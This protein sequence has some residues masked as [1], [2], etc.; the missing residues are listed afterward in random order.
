VNIVVVGG[1]PVGSLLAW[2]LATGGSAVT[3]VRRRSTDEGSG[4]IVVARGGGSEAV[5]LDFA[6]STQVVDT[7][8]DAVVLAMKA[9]DVESTVAS[10]PSSVATV[11]T[12]QNGIGSEEAV[13]EARPQG[14]LIAAS[15]TAS[16]ELEPDGAVRWRRRGGIGLARVREGG[17]ISPDSLAEILERGGLPARVYADWRAMKWSK[18]IGN[19]VGNA[20]SALLDMTPG[21]VYQHPDLFEI[22]RSQLR[23]A[24]AVV[25][26]LGLD[27][28]GL[29]DADVRRLELALNAPAL[30][31]RPVLA[32][33]VASARGG[34][35]PSLRI[36]LSAAESAP[37]Q[38]EIAWL[39]GAVARTAG[40][41]GV[42]APVNAAL[43]ALVERSTTDASLR[44]SLRHQ[45]HAL[46]AAIGEFVRRPLS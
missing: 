11:V 34:K 2:V 12:V 23:E 24:F 30:L 10:L 44:A 32:R 31:S 16:V 8:T 13:L 19:L 41:V 35:E 26:A 6:R 29:P 5:P 3:L 40:S 46:V 14:S 37:V 15:L 33:I 20:T 4:P 18:L 42:G 43:T 27:L 1:G 45:P 7:R 21:D 36:G 17:R 9:Y 38:S 39:N 25:R 28:V 22:E